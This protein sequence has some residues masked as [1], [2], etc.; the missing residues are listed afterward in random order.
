MRRHIET[1]EGIYR[2]A[3]REVLTRAFS[4]AGMREYLEIVDSDDGGSEIRI[5]LR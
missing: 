3:A 1:L 2:E 5:R 4:V